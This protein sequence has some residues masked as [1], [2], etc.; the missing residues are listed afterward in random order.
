MPVCFWLLRARQRHLAPCLRAAGV[1]GS[2]YVFT[3][4]FC[5][6]FLFVCCYLCALGFGFGAA[7]SPS[8]RPPVRST[9]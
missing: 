3:C 5:D 1:A 6:L 4:I 2:P 8:P 9:V 7:F